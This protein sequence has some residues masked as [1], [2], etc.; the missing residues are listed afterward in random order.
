M[1]AI[2]IVGTARASEPKMFSTRGMPSSTKLLRNS[3][4]SMAPLE[5]LSFSTVHTTTAEINSMTNKEITVNMIS[6][7]RK[8]VA[9]V[10]VYM[11]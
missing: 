1:N 10:V 7:G 4:C 2:I 9:S 6:R 11:L 8:A 5:R 3:A